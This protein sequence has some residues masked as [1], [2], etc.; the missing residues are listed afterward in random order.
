MF[1]KKVDSAPYDRP[2]NCRD[3]SKSLTDTGFALEKFELNVILPPAYLFAHLPRFSARITTVICS[4][5]ERYMKKLLAPHFA[6]HMVV[7]ARKI[8]SGR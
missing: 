8:A 1:R 7:C 3:L 6:R 2:I 5:L 4:F